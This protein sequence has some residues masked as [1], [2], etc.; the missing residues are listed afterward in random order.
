MQRLIIV[1]IVLFSFG[2]LAAQAQLPDGAD[3]EVRLSP[4][5]SGNWRVEY[6]FAEP[7][8]VLALVRST[9]DYREL[10]WS[11]TS[12]NARFGRVAGIDVIA[13]DEPA[14]TVSFSIIPLTSTLVGEYTPFVTFADGSVAVHDGQFSVA[15]LD[16]LEAVEALEGDT[17]NIG[18]PALSMD[19][20]L[21]SDTPI[22]VDGEVHQ[23]KVRHRVDGD[24]TY[25]YLGNSEIE[26]FD[27]FTAVIDKRLPAWL[28]DRFDSD[29]EAI[30]SA[31]EQLWGFDLEHKATVML[32]Y[33][34]AT[35]DGFSVTG[36]ALDQLLMME[37]G[38]T[39]L[40]A[41]DDDV[42]SYVHWFFAHEAAHLFQIDRGV[43][44]AS[45][46]QSWI[47]EGAAN[48][49][50]YSLIASMM[51]QDGA[52]RFLAG[53]Y[54][55]AFDECVTTLEAGPL[56][57][58]A[59]REAFSAHYSCGDFIALATDGFLKQRNLYGFWNRLVSMAKGEPDEKVDED[60][61][62]STM[63]ILGATKAQRNA[64]RAL[65]EGRPD[66]ARKTLTNLLEK[67]GLEPE[68]SAGGQLIALKWPDY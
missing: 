10:T 1:F 46:A 38:G 22:I 52:K 17:S 60:T 13:L 34:G 6:T 36:G 11:V 66:N 12:D 68:F 45:G 2:G 64:V 35:A 20:V 33:K 30:F 48:T 53:V 47:H 63:Q 14:R 16:S 67:A 37:M 41:P 24:G 49:M 50:A 56:A 59:E 51:E 43:G 31:Y 21:S 39:A 8:S 62:F 58:A 18:V 29:L 28:R 3:A 42:L 4:E 15:P 57:T 9:G 65:V 40:N 61:Y 19:V 7:Q 26:E 5:E 23:G 25:I 32:A 44:F 54:G 27:S 55:R